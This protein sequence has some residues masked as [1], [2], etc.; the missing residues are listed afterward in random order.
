MA[1]WQTTLSSDEMDA[2]IKGTMIEHLGIRVTKIGDDYITA[3]MPVDHRTRQPYGILHGGASVTLAETLGSFAAHMAVPPGTR[4]VGLEIN[5]NHIRSKRQGLVTGV[6][7]PI[8][9]GRTTHIWDIQICD[10][11]D[12]PICVSR[13]TI[14]VLKP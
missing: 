5:A 3:T 11:S 7:R 12:R 2:F 14:A 6:A 8:H 10:E 13:L 4:C 1:I 9:I